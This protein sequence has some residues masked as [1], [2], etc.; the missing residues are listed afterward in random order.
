MKGTIALKSSMK[1][2]R[3][4]LERYER[5]KRNVDWYNVRLPITASPHHLPRFDGDLHMSPAALQTN[6]PCRNQGLQFKIHTP[7]S[8]ANL[9]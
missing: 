5:I 7:L 3:R 4:K 9:V 6:H 8:P 1:E 2:K